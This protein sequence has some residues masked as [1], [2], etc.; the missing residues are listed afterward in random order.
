MSKKKNEIMLRPYQN[1]AIEAIYREWKNGNKRTLLN[2]ATGLGKTI[3][4]SKVAERF[5]KNGGRVLILAHREELLNQAAEKIKKITGLKCVYEKAKITSIGSDC[6]I[7]LGSIQ[8]ISRPTRLCKFGK[9]YFDLI[10]IDEAHH[11]MS[12][13]YQRVLEYFDKAYVLGVTATPNR[14][15]KKELSDYFDSEAYEYGI[16]EGVNNHWLCPIVAQTIP[17][18]I[19]ISH[20]KQN[21]G[22]FS[23]SGSDEAIEPYLER[24]AKVIAE[25]YYEKKTVIFLPLV[26]T[27]KKMCDILNDYGVPAVEINGNTEDRVQRFKDYAKGKYKVLCNAMLATE[28][29]DCPSVDC[30]VVLRPTK[31]QGFYQQMVGRGT[32]L[33][34]GKENLL[35]LDFLWL[36]DRINLCRPSSLFSKTL[37]E[38]ELARKYLEGASAPTELMR[39]AD[40]VK[41]DIQFQTERT[42]AEE[43]K[44][45][46]G[47]K[48]K[49]IDPL[50]FSAATGILDV[51]SSYQPIFE[52]ETNGPTKKQVEMLE[53]NSIDTSTITYKGLASVLIDKIINRSQLGLCTPKQIRLLNSYGFNNVAD[54]TIDQAKNMIDKIARN[55]WTVPGYINVDT[56]NPYKRLNTL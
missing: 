20:V 9:A 39:L 35:L 3:V 54:W 10:I 42:L 43:L 25:N 53:N 26:N 38:D 56:Y 47:R 12:E 49:L 28:G 23:L 37:S 1:E 2:L 15:D 55:N 36:T 19:D 27:S 22:D 50:Q 5:A 52:W 6:K 41:G 40:K 31:I 45:M 8:T 29:W 18:K 13:T 44:K 21:S 30:I 17:L 33:Y 14:G 51:V 34:P 32:R 11:C 7:V 4:F 46:R 16:R 24:I 48:G